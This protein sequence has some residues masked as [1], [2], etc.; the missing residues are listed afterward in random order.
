MALRG[1]GQSRKPKA[2]VSMWAQSEKSGPGSQTFFIHP[3]VTI[4]LT[5]RMSAPATL[6]S[7]INARADDVLGE[8]F[9]V[10]ALAGEHPACAVG[11]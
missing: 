7:G 2:S 5:Q 1:V 10:L 4:R 6:M 11:R 9:H 8:P 3:K